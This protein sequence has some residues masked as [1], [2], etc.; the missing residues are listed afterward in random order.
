MTVTGDHQDRG[1]QHVLLVE[2]SDT[3]ADFPTVANTSCDAIWLPASL[4][5]AVATVQ[6]AFGPGGSLRFP[7]LVWWTAFPGP[8]TLPWT[9]FWPAIA[10]RRPQNFAG[11]V[12]L[13]ALDALA[14]HVRSLLAPAYAGAMSSWEDAEADRDEVLQRA[15]KALSGEADNDYLRGWQTAWTVVQSV[16][17][18]QSSGRGQPGADA[19]A[20]S[21]GLDRDAL[22]QRAAKALRSEPTSDYF[23]GWLGAWK[24]LI[25]VLDAQDQ[26]RSLLA[27]APS[28]RPGS[29]Q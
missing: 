26:M 19:D 20:I 5:E 9:T 3:D 1:R 10:A 23:R 22:R 2:T 6:R 27:A 21:P 24:E 29:S 11:M 17:S 18:A 7:C 28:M 13:E 25:S 8:T 16:V 12:V 14:E 15:A 4:E